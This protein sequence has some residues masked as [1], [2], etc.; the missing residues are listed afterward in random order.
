HR[1][2]MS[3]IVGLPGCGKTFLALD[4]DAHI[5][6]GVAWFGHRCRQTPVVYLAAEGGTAIFN[7]VAAVK[8]RFGF[9]DSLP[10]A[11][12]PASLELVSGRIADSRPVAASGR[13]S[14]MFGPPVGKVTIDTV[15]RTLA[16]AR[17]SSPEGM[18]A[19][20]RNVDAVRAGAT[21]HVCLLHHA[22]KD[23]T[24]G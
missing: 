14:A 9:D 24:S 22:P 18:G 1:G 6:A 20:I 13:V 21:V 23:G 8:A 5:A 3:A 19:L 12:I 11:I 2:E 16:G 7:R 10:L 17:E 15:S 4:M